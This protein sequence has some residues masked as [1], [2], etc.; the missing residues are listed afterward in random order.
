MRFFLYFIEIKRYSLRWNKIENLYFLVY[1]IKVAP[2]ARIIIIMR[3]CHVK[4]LIDNQHYNFFLQ[5]VF[6]DLVLT[7]HNKH[8]RPYMYSSHTHICSLRYELAWCYTQCIRGAAGALT[9]NLIMCSLCIQ[10]YLLHVCAAYPYTEHWYIIGMKYYIQN[11]M[12]SSYYYYYYSCLWIFNLTLTCERR[13]RNN[14]TT[15]RSFLG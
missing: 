4:W 1:F 9:K 13:S 15:C 2:C 5:I 6:I 10:K 7:E 8:K 11:C 12:M 14:N 3:S